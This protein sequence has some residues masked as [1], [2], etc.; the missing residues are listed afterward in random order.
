MNK[1]YLESN[2]LAASPS[3]YLD[4][5]YANLQMHALSVRD[6]LAKVLTALSSCSLT[7][8][9]GRIDIDLTTAAMQQSTVNWLQA[10][11]TLKTLLPKESDNKDQYDTAFECIA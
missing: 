9:M 8:V 11:A 1:Y 2:L 5:L 7:T 3:S 10:D 6:G 4:S